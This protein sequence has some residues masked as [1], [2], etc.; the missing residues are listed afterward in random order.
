METSTNVDLWQ[1]ILQVKELD[2]SWS[3]D[4]C[5]QMFEC[6]QKRWECEFLDLSGEPS[7][8]NSLVE[9][10]RYTQKWCLWA[11]REYRRLEGEEKAR[12]P[13]STR[14][15]WYVSLGRL[16]MERLSKL[17]SDPKTSELMELHIRQ[18]LDLLNCRVLSLGPLSGLRGELDDLRRDRLGTL[19]RPRIERWDLAIPEEILNQFERDQLYKSVRELK[20][21]WVS[22]TQ[23]YEQKL[24]GIN[25]TM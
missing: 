3:D 10:Q 6:A 24:R 5:A 7:V 22:E 8:P 16:Q 18:D 2:H 25:V 23:E 15:A 12:D 9:P 17:G 1:Q 14:E 21:E 13:E 19:C 4:M 20:R 11:E